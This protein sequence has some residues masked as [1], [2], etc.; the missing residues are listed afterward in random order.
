MRLA[1]ICGVLVVWAVQAQA[2]Q[3]S[4]TEL[5]ALLTED[6][7]NVRGHA[8]RVVAEASEPELNIDLAAAHTT[9]VS[10]NLRN[11]EQ[12]L[13]A[14]RKLLSADQLKRVREHQEYLEKLCGRLKD[15]TEK[16]EKE[17]SKE[18]PD[19][20]EVRRTASSLRAEMDRGRQEHALL[21]QKLGLK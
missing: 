8:G 21:K 10:K 19:R 16:L 3:P 6:C 12:R 13:Q 5:H 9:E 17:L 14:A 4:L 15:L 2:R 1:W 18:K 20:I 7:K 11:M